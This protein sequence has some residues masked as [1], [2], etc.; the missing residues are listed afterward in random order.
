M[1]NKMENSELSKKGLKLKD[2]IDY[3][4]GSIVSKMLLDK[5]SGSVTLF[6][7]DKGQGLSEH[8]APFDALVYNIEGSLIIGIEENRHELKKG[9]VILLPADRMHSLKSVEASKIML[10]M[11]KSA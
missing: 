10:I 11:I 5:G 8:K 9:E 6:A 4:D 1:N 3:S 2:L 7:F